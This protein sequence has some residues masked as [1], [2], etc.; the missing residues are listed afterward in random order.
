MTAQRRWWLGAALLLAACGDDEAP[1]PGAAAG[2]SGTSGQTAP[3]GSSGQTGASGGGAGG[4]GGRAG[5]GGTGLAGQAS[6]GGSTGGSSLP[7]GGSGGLAGASVA[8]AAGLSGTSGHSGTGGLPGSLC[9][10]AP[11]TPPSLTSAAHA[12]LG[13]GQPDFLFE[14]QDGGQGAHTGPVLDQAIVDQGLGDVIARQRFCDEVTRSWRV[15]RVDTDGLPLPLMGEWD[16]S[17]IHIASTDQDGSGL[18]RASFVCFDPVQTPG[19]PALET[20]AQAYERAAVYFQQRVAHDREVYPT[21]QHFIGHTG[22]Y[23][24]GHYSAALGAPLIASE[25]GENINSTQA[26]VAFTRGAGRQFGVP[27]GIDMSPWFGNG[28]PDYWTGQDRVWCGSDPNDC[29]S[30]SDHGHSLSLHRRTWW[31]SYLAGARYVMQEGASVNFFSSPAADAGLSPLGLEAQ[32][33]HTLTSLHPDRG[34]PHVPFAVVT[35]YYHGLGLGTWSRPPGQEVSWNHF[36]IT[37]APRST[38]ALLDALWPGSFRVWDTPLSESRYLVDSAV[39]NTV[40]VLVDV[41]SQLSLETLLRYNVLYLSGDV[42][43][44]ADTVK[45]FLAQ[46]GRWVVLES[47]AHDALLTA[48]GEVTFGAFLPDQDATAVGISYQL[49]GPLVRVAS[50]GLYP[51]VVRAIAPYFLPFVVSDGLDFSLGRVGASSWR[52]A[53]FNHQGVDKQPRSPEVTTGSPRSVTLTASPGSSFQGVTSWLT[54]STP[55]WS[56]AT[57]TLTI[58]PGDVAVLALDMSP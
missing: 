19:C 12:L 16:Y 27:W 4:L 23:L 26:H 53:L 25:V 18:E 8:G 20:V 55:T 43:V 9:G 46:P 14:L 48:L 41:A 15:E 50:P 58:A 35:G 21:S 44:S 24:F 34:Q 2:A 52:L 37:G 7:V 32:T 45:A 42:N 10:A 36:P 38:L 1:A 40:D 30:G 11:T 6:G 28:V 5:T 54:S 57:V 49:G 33:F 3:G 39:G 51:T 56:P 17:L 31:L 29:A 47:P 13:P 22:H